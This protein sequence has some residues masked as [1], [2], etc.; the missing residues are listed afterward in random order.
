MFARAGHQVQVASFATQEAV[1]A[2]AAVQGVV[3]GEAVQNVGPCIAI[4]PVVAFIACAVEG[5]GACE[6]QVLQVGAQRPGQC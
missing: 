1:G 2:R 6:G 4:Q 3:A 5:G